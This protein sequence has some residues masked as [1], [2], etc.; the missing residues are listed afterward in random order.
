MDSLLKNAPAGSEPFVASFKSAASTAN[1]AYE[2]AMQSLRGLAPQ[3][4]P[5]APT[6]S[7]RKAA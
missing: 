7:K 3:F 5:A 2:T 1:Q 6:P 4:E